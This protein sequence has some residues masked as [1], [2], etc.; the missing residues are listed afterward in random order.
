MTGISKT[1][2]GLKSGTKYFIR[3]TVN[4]SHFGSKTATYERVTLTLPPTG[5]TVSNKKVNSFT[6]SWNAVP[7]ATKYI[8]YLTFPN[9]KTRTV[10]TTSTSLAL[11]NLYP[12]AIHSFYVR[13]RNQASTYSDNSATGS[14]DLP[15]GV[16]APQITEIS[17]PLNASLFRWTAVSGASQYWYIITNASGGNPKYYNPTAQTNALISHYNI[18]IAPY[19]TYNF[20]VR[21]SFYVNYGSTT[22]H[23][24]SSYASRSFYYT[25]EFGG[26]GGDG[27]GLNIQGYPNPTVGKIHYQL[28]ASP[29]EGESLRYVVYDSY[30]FRINDGMLSQSG[31]DLSQERNGTYIIKIYENNKLVKTERVVKN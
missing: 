19:A 25:G 10:G 7:R 31:I 15:G 27:F 14:V 3:A 29:Q 16:Y 9:G 17:F 11:G 18:G 20:K 13:S 5:L 1:V 12:G 8:V 26:L 30:G 4:D 24:Y 23:V 22:E 28:K 2:T 21:A 6:L